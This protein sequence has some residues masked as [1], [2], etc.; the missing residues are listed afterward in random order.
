MSGYY[1][2]SKS[3]NAVLAERQGRFP[4]TVIGEHLN[5]PYKFIQETCQWAII[6]GEWHHTSMYFNQ[7]KYYDENKIRLWV[8]N[9]KEMIKERGQRF[10]TALEKWIREKLDHTYQPKNNFKEYLNCSI[11]YLEWMGKGKM[12]KPTAKMGRGKV[13]DIGG[14]F[15]SCI[16]QDGQR[17][18]KAK[19]AKGFQVFDSL[20]KRLQFQLV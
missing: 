12:A 11:I 10:D 3:N 7:T 20:G 9:D 19:T 18:R 5:I 2:L 17:F 1:Q 14:K 8:E 15:V 4:A 16:M 13:I 6:K